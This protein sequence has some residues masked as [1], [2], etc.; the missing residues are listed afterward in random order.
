MTRTLPA[1]TLPP[2]FTVGAMAVLLRRHGA[3][4]RDVQQCLGQMKVLPAQEL[5]K[6]LLVEAL[7]KNVQA[8]LAYV[9]RVAP[10]LLA[11]SETSATPASPPDAAVEPES[12]PGNSE[13]EHNGARSGAPSA[14]EEPSPAAAQPKKRGP[15]TAPST[16]EPASAQP[17]LAWPWAALARWVRP[18]K[19][20]DTYEAGVYGASL[21]AMAERIEREHLCPGLLERFLPG[22]NAGLLRELAA[23]A[24]VCATLEFN[25]AMAALH[26]AADCTRRGL[27]DVAAPM[28]RLDVDKAGAWLG[29]LHPVIPPKALIINLKPNDD[30]ERARGKAPGLPTGTEGTSWKLIPWRPGP[31]ASLAARAAALRLAVDAGGNI[32]MRLGD[33]DDSHNLIALDFDTEEAATSLL[34][35]HARQ[36]I[37]THCGK[38]AVRRFGRVGRGMLLLRSDQPM[39]KAEITFEGRQKI[40]LLGQGQQIAFDGQHPSDV[41]YR[42]EPLLHELAPNDLPELTVQEVAELMRE[43]RELAELAGLRVLSKTDARAASSQPAPPN[44]SVLAGDTEEVRDLLALIPSPDDRHKWVEILAA[45]KGATSSD[46]AV[47]LE[48][49]LDWSHRDSEAEVAETE[50]VWNSLGPHSGI[51]EL[52]RHAG[53]PSSR[54]EEVFNVQPAATAAGVD[55]CAMF[56]ASGTAAPSPSAA[57]AAPNWVVIGDEPEE[58]PEGQWVLRG[59]IDEGDLAVVYGAPGSAKTWLAV[60]MSVH[61]AAAREWFAHET[62]A[63]IGVVYVANENSPGVRRRIRAQ[64]QA[65]GAE[66]AA[67]P[68]VV[69]RK[70]VNMKGDFSGV[71]TQVQAAHAELVARFAVRHV[72]LVFDTLARVWGGINDNAAEDMGMVIGHCDALRGLGYTVLLVHHTGKDSGKGPRGHSSL[73]GAVDVSVLVER[74]DGGARSYRV[75]KLR[76]GEDG[77]TRAFELRSVTMKTAAG[78]PISSAV[79]ADIGQPVARTKIKMPTGYAADALRSLRE[80]VRQFGQVFDNGKP[81]PERPKAVTMDQWREVH[82]TSFGTLTPAERKLEHQGFRRAMQAMEEEGWIARHGDHVW[83][84]R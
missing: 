47:G 54:A 67:L 69:T 4:E 63:T 29:R 40:E 82:F 51:A 19:G 30:P 64:A 10:A 41:P 5:D 22:L 80:C 37:L 72:L 18:A 74:G 56:A 17:E 66:L 3:S 68:L 7:P 61:L 16:D 53:R 11:P 31:W 15:S 1:S 28:D 77:E 81:P 2:N 23:D 48:L 13:P 79:V 34:L 73:L 58:P 55:A 71:L 35:K 76:E 49:A 46:P 43:L 83:T 26:A 21:L 70:P 24:R 60:S 33:S 42:T 62:A 59:L 6:H 45:L 27:R 39:R 12:D 75:D 32:G 50:R 52:R 8:C 36:F 20:A 65:M 9:K 84:T 25:V 44:S 38:E 78:E 14:G 57:P